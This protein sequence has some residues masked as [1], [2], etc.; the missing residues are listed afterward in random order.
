MNRKL[1]L[2]VAGIIFS[3][4]ALIHLLRLLYQWEITIGGAIV[5]MTFSCAGLVVA[6]LLA[7]WMFVAAK[8]K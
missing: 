4:V 2:V 1:P 8:A 7:I 5:P 3:L 6:A